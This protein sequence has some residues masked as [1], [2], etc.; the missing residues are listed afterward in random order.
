MMT[1]LLQMSSN[2]GNKYTSVL[3]AALV[4]VGAV[5]SA[6]G[7]KFAKYTEAFMPFLISAL[8]PQEDSE[9][10]TTA[11]MLVGDMVS[12]FKK[13]MAPQANDIMSILMENLASS[14]LHRDVKPSIISTFARMAEN[15][16]DQFEPFLPHTMQVLQQAGQ[17]QIDDV[18]FLS[19]FLNDGRAEPGIEHSVRSCRLHPRT[20]REHTR[21]LY[22]HRPR[23]L[24]RQQE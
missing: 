5:V 11:T 13:D 8:R 4:T 23:L 16:G 6:L 3:D 21:S 14:S 1:V 24:T 15:L 18:R 10:C 20:S 17:M 7:T 9:L 12:A 22:R 19:W 2:H